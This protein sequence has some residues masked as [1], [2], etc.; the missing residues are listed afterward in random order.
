M[1]GKAKKRGY[2]DRER[3]ERVRRYRQL[4]TL[5]EAVEHE[6]LEQAA[7]ALGIDLK[8]ASNDLRDLKA[9]LGAEAFTEGTNHATEHSQE[10]M[11]LGGMLSHVFDVLNARARQIVRI[12]MT[13]HVSRNYLPR[14]LAR[15]ERLVV[16]SQPR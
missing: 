4:V 7:R 8:T 9:W 12:A 1:A 3:E 14:L 16:I 11:V 10:L 13:S 5:A 2:P 6:D 15:P